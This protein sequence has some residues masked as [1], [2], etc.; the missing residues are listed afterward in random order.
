MQRGVVILNRSTLAFLGT[1]VVAALLIC[2]VI[3]RVE[4]QVGAGGMAVGWQHVDTPPA[5]TDLADPWLELPDAWTEAA[6]PRSTEIGPATH[7][8]G[9]V[10]AVADGVV[11]FA[12]LRNEEHAVILLHRDADGNRFES[13]Y[14]PLASA[15]VRPGELIG[16]GMPVG[17]LGDALRLPV[18]SAMPAGA[19]TVDFGK[20]PLAVQIESADE[21]WMSLEIGNAEKILELE[22]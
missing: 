4:R 14:R 2:W 20:S 7:E 16:R 21:S 8:G 12:G 17:R 18:I 3:L 11:I 10:F 9:D 15:T 19:V 1:L 6:A 5:G 22:N 13:V